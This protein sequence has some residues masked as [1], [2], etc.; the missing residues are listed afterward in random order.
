M[1]DVNQTGESTKTQFAWI[2]AS[3]FLRVEQ[4]REDLQSIWTC[5][6]TADLLTACKT[7]LVE[8]FDEFDDLDTPSRISAGLSSPAAIPRR[9]LRLFERDPD[10]LPS[11]LQV[12]A[13]SQT[14]ANRLIADPE[15]FDLD[16]GQW[17]AT[18]PRKFLVD[19]LVA[20]MQGLESPV[21][22]RWRF[23]NSSVAN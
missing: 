13:T 4:A 18:G 2:D 1:N 23:D 8:R 3:R 7:Q 15:S 17:R 6:A 11:L 9:L 14:L 22:L 19:E 20:E 5:G 12:F 10:A 21:G 16:A